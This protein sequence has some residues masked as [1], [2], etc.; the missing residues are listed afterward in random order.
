MGERKRFDELDIMK[1]IDIML[2]VFYHLESGT[3]IMRF[4]YSFHL[5][6]FFVCSGFVGKRIWGKEYLGCNF[7]KCQV[8]VSAISCLESPFTN[9]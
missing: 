8:I 5:F 1:G 7:S 6:L 9:G 3:Y 4:V 2:I